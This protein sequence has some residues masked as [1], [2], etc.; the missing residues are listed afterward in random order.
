MKP[1]NRLGAN[2]CSNTISVFGINGDLL[3][4]R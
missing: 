4:L 2:A 3:R 1:V